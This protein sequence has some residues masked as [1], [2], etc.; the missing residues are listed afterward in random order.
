MSIVPNA[1]AE[2]NYYATVLNWRVVPCHT[3]TTE[4]GCS[5]GSP[6][7][8]KPGKHPRLSKWQEKATTDP[9]QVAKWWG[10]WP[11]AN[12]GLALGPASGVFDIEFDDAE[13]E[14]TAAELLGDV[15]TLKYRSQRS[16]HHLFY[17]PEDLSPPKAVLRWRGLELRFGTD[18]AGPCPFFR[19][20]STQVAVATSG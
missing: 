2:A 6:S 19:R 14:A 20:H 18:K 3:P 15:A 1:A 17:L 11:D 10:Q 9:D 16:T 5:C 7:C 4:G 12:V 8:K 13:G